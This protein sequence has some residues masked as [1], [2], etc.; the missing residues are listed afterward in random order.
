MKSYNLENGT[1]GVRPLPTT[2]GKVKSSPNKGSYSS[3]IKGP[4]NVLLCD[5]CDG[6]GHTS[7]HADG[8]VWCLNLLVCDVCGSSGHDE[9]HCRRDWCETCRTDGLGHNFVGHTVERCRKHHVCSKCNVLGHLEDRCRTCAKCNRNT[10][11]TDQCEVDVTCVT[12]NTVGHSEKRC[13]SCRSCG[14]RLPSK[15]D[16]WEHKCKRDKFTHACVQCDAPGSG[17]CLCYAH[18]S[19]NKKK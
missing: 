9:A 18:V 3:P 11:S 4:K 8:S 13:R 7:H 1:C 14:F 5:H 6:K 12:C 10:H 16:E 15:H 17:K 19:P 2:G